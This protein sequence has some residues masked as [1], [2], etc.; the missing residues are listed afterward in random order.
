MQMF[1][2]GYAAT[3]DVNNIS[4]IIADHDRT[5]ESRALIRAYET[6][7]YFTV[8]ERTDRAEVVTTALDKG[9]ATVG[10]TIPPGFARD[11][12]AHRASVQTVIDGSDAN[13]ANVAQSY[14]AQIASAVRT[15]MTGTRVGGGSTCVRAPG[16]TRASRAGTST[17]PR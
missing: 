6:T 10:L 8:V 17:F 14:A 2:L 4:T 16:S 13:L 5:V 3:T 15:T 11:L 7:G 12:A 9:R 1:L